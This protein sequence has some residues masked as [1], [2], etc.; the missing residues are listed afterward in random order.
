MLTGRRREDGLACFQ[1]A[2]HAEVHEQQQAGIARGNGMIRG[3]AKYRDAGELRGSQD[4][5][6]A[7][8]APQGGLDNSQSGAIVIGHYISRHGYAHRGKDFLPQGFQG[9]MQE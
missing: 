3:R 8:F 6:G 9:V 2:V 5:A 4:L 7:G 1:P